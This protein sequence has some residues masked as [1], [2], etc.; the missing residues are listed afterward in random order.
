MLKTQISAA[1]RTSF[2]NQANEAY[3]ENSPESMGMKFCNGLPDSTGPAARN[4]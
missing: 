3:K 1:F 2:R 4:P